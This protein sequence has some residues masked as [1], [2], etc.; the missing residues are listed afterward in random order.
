[1]TAFS[2]SIA[3]LMQRKDPNQLWYWIFV[4]VCIG[5]ILPVFFLGAVDPLIF[6]IPLWAAVSLI[7]TCVLSVLT[8]IQVRFRW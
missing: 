3:F 7:S 1:V 4:F 2:S 8:L 5:G 6:G